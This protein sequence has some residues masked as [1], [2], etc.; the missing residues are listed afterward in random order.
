MNADTYNLQF[1]PDGLTTKKRNSTPRRA[2]LAGAFLFLEYHAFGTTLI[3]DLRFIYT[4]RHAWLAYMVDAPPTTDKILQTGVRK[5][6][7][8]EHRANL[9]LSRGA[10]KTYSTYAL[11]SID[12]AHHLVVIEL[13]MHQQNTP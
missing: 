5:W 7:L 6:E 11:P 13:T 8:A 9:T 2:N 1:V 12:F 10:F 4:F 3:V